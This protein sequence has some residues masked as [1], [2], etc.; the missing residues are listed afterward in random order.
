MKYFHG[1]NRKRPYFEGWYYKQQNATQTLAFIPS[2][3]V[4]KNGQA[5]AHLQVITQSESY[6]QAYSIEDFA[7]CHG[8]NGTW[9]RDSRKIKLHTMDQA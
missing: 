3:H 2:F 6:Y 1:V 4:D 8:S 5:G 9:I 7:V